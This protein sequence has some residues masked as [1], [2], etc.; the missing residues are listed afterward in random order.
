MATS[1]IC[2]HS[3]VNNPLQRGRLCAINTV[4]VLGFFG[5]GYKT[6]HVAKYIKL[7]FTIETA[8]SEIALST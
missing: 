7:F 8:K 5:Y 1:I 2:G 6:V 4:F 3:L